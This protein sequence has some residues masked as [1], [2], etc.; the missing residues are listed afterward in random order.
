MI[1]GQIINIIYVFAMLIAIIWFIVGM[2]LGIVFGILA[3][4]GNNQDQNAKYKK[5]ALISLA[6]LPLLVLLFLIYFLLN[7]VLS[8]FGVSMSSFSIPLIK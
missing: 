4:T 3:I 1:V 2:P 5:I 7:I 6:G 8:L